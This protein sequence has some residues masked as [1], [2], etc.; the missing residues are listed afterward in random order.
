MKKRVAQ[1]VGVS[2]PAIQPLLQFLPIFESSGFGTW[3]D[4]QG[5]LP[6]AVLSSGASDFLQALYDRGWILDFDWP[7]WQR[8]AKLYLDSP[9]R[10]RNAD[11]PTI[12]KLLTT[13]ARKD[14]FC[15]GHLLEMLESG[16]IT[17]ILRRLE[18]LAG[19]KVV[20]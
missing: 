4:P 17:L 20:P 5:Q 7:S 11:I 3:M 15:E 13:H 16:H 10:L 6:Y 1:N 2:T 8:E 9:D 12:Q 14:R 18:D 19:G